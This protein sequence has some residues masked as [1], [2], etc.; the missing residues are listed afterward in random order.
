MRPCFTYLHLFCSIL[1]PQI[2]IIQHLFTYIHIFILLA[3]SD[4]S[5][6]GQ[7]DRWLS[8]WMEV[9]SWIGKWNNVLKSPF[10]HS[11][12]IFLTKSSQFHDKPQKH[13]LKY[14]SRVCLRYLFVGFKLQ[15]LVSWHPFC[16]SSG[17]K[18]NNF[19]FSS[20]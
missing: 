17:R 3:D 5:L 9:S 15:A 7:W 14:L 6:G 16:L 10:R 1:N 2:Y 8:Q 13:V 18:K 4:L 19:C 12:Y 20:C 11:R